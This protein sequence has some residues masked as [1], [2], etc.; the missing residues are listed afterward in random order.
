MPNDA[1]IARWRSDTGQA[2]LDRNARMMTTLAP[3]AELLIERAAPRPGERVVD[4]GCG[5]GETTRLVADAVGANGHVLG[6]DVSPMLLDVARQRTGERGEVSWLLADAQVHSFEPVFDLV[7]SRFGV[8][9]FDDPVAAF[10]N[11]GHA[12][13]PGGRLAVIVWQGPGRD[14]LQF[15]I[16]NQ[17]AAGLVEMPPPPGPEEPGPLSFGDPERVQRILG[18]AGFQRI[19]LEPVVVEM[20]MGPPDTA[21]VA[22]DMM[23]LSRAREVFATIDEA[24]AQQVSANIEAALQAH[25]RHDGIWLPG[26]VFAVT[27]HRP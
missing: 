12:L 6:V 20:W 13:K 1:E 19:E 21:V 8:M 18:A 10:A 2:W 3:F 25:R 17:A 9:F 5:T 11:L 22:H 16:P 15:V 23:K 4:V 26:A 27:A 14:N 24:T 7:V